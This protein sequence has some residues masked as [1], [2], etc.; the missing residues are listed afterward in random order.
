MPITADLGGK[1]YTLG[2]GK[3]F[4]D[5]YPDGVAITA[6]T[7]GSGERYF[8]NTPEFS[9]T[10]TSEDLDHFDSD[11]GIRT[12]DDSV[13]LSF[14]RTGTVVCDN[15]SAD[16]IALQ[17]LGDDPSTVVT[18]SATAV[19]DSDKVG[20]KRGTFIQLG[21]TTA[22]PSGVRNVSNVLV[23]KVVAGVP[24]VITPAGNIEVDEALGRVYIED[25]ATATAIAD[26]DTL[27]FTY[28]VAATTREQVISKNKSIYGA[29][30]YVADNP[31]GTNRDFYFPYV[32]LTPDGDYA[33]KGDDWQQMTFAV[34]ILKKSSNIES[35]YVDGRAVSTP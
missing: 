6:T 15:I 8:G 22:L 7:Q 11:S 12:K 10:S 4:F 25:V 23:S 32:K 28:D 19:V 26:G 34:E 13:Q 2:R 21:A 35:V 20:V 27:R 18:A 5:R 31:K 24:T 17:F 14:D 9:T 33:F 30:R 29:L 16:N 1:D 3:I